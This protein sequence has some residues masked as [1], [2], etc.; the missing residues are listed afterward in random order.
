MLAR[1]PMFN[2]FANVVG[3]AAAARPFDVDIAALIGRPPAGR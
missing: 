2:A 1:S 3:A